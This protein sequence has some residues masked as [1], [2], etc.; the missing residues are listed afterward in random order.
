MTIKPPA[1][2]STV[3]A[4]RVRTKTSSSTSSMV[5][6]DADTDVFDDENVSP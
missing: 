5:I 3:Y 4:C 2:Y 1:A 6:I